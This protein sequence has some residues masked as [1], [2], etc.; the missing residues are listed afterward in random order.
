MYRGVIFYSILSTVRFNEE[1]K[2]Y[3]EHLKNRNKHTTSA[4]IAVMRKLILLAHSLYKNNVDYNP[5][6]FKL[7]KSIQKEMCAA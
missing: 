4:Q 1:F 6:Q 5:E 3:Y 2:A 7:K